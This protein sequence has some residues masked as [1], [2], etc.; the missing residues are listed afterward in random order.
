MQVEHIQPE[1]IVKQGGY[2]DVITVTSP[3]KTIY[4]GGQNAIDSEGNLVGAG[5]LGAQTTKVLENVQACLHAAGATIEDIVKWT[6]YVE[7]GQELH[8][9]FEAFMK[10]W[11][12]RPNPPTLTV[13]QVVALAFPG[14]LTEIEAIAVVP[15]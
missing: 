15:A 9:G 11:G 10:I 7:H 3:S 5:D 6:I 8:T 4:I 13:V 14:A 1:G 2:T 12:D